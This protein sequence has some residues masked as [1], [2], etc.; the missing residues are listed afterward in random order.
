MVLDYYFGRPYSMLTD[1]PVSAEKDAEL[2]EALNN[3]TAKVKLLYH[4]FIKEYG[5]TVC[6]SLHVQLYGRV[7]YF[8]E[9]HDL[10]TFVGIG[11]HDDPRTA[12][13]KNTCCQLVGDSAKFTM[14]ILID[15]GGIEL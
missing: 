11:G 5:T 14:E 15:N 9:E 3:A 8:A 4:R 7:F 6:P 2:G 10:N 12:G 1:K 13:H